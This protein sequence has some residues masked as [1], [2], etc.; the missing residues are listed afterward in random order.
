MTHALGLV[1]GFGR[2]G[3][4]VTTISGPRVRT[5]D[6]SDRHVSVSNGICWQARLVKTL[7]VLLRKKRRTKFD[8]LLYRYTIGQPWTTMAVVLLCRVH[9]IE[10]VAEV[11]SLSIHYLERLGPQILKRALRFESWM[12][13]QFDMVYVVSERV[14]VELEGGGCHAPIAVVP[15]GA[16]P[17]EPAIVGSSSESADPRIVYMGT[18][19]PY[20][21]FE[22]V[23]NSLEHLPDEVRLHV[24]GD[25]PARRQFE[26]HPTSTSGRVVLHGAY[27]RES[28]GQLCNPEHDILLMP[29]STGTF[30]SP[31]KMYEYMSLGVPIVASQQGEGGK[32]LE[33]GKS[34]YLFEPN[35]TSSI[36]DAI[37]RALSDP[38]GRR[39]AGDLAREIFLQG[40]TWESRVASLLRYC[41][42]S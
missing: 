8:L 16:S 26:A 19:Q 17:I 38:I 13:A 24:F 10:S 35:S 22:V 41:S 5:S 7:A 2:L 11:N 4:R 28:L 29:H 30:G 3:W 14:K 23:L 37:D 33:D 1:E 6:G 18:L 32:L 15:N 25:G 27:R 39:R 36:A 31:T 21:D 40:H 9:R 12:L 20:Y 42:L 34:G